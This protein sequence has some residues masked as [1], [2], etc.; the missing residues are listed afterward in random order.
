MTL[1][2]GMKYE[3]IIGENKPTNDELLPCPFCGSKANIFYDEYLQLWRIQCSSY[4]RCT[5]KA[6]DE[7]C[8]VIKSWNTR[9]PTAP[10]RV[11]LNSDLGELANEIKKVIKHYKMVGSRMELHDHIAYTVSQHFKPPVDNRVELDK[12][13][14]KEC[15]KLCFMALALQFWKNDIDKVLDYLVKEICQDFKPPSPAVPYIGAI[16]DCLYKATPD[17]SH[18]LRDKQARA[19]HA[20][21]TSL[22]QKEK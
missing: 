16:Y 5:E 12:V 3:K 15:L 13:K 8:K 2:N 4:D 21:L 20:Y 14:L 9:T 19:I 22:N 18:V 7:E 17:S 10:M 1:D 11:E 6:Q